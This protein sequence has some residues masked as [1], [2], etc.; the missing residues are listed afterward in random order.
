MENY[1]YFLVSSQ[2][3]LSGAGGKGR[4]SFH[5]QKGF[6]WKKTIF[7]CIIA[8]DLYNSLILIFTIILEIIFYGFIQTIGYSRKCVELESLDL[9]LHVRSVFTL[10]LQIIFIYG[11]V[12]PKDY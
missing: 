1:L 6:M 10:G 9:P 11:R 4:G 3:Y 7:M 8:F 5:K 2:N 12:S